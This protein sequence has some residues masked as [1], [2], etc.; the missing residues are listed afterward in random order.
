MSLFD[1]AIASRLDE[2]L[3]GWLTTVRTDGR[4]QSSLVWFLR[5]GDDLLIYSRADAGKLANIAAHPSVAF[6]LNSDH[7][8]DAYVTMEA[9]A[10]IVDAPIPADKVPAYLAKYA[11]EIAHFGWT[12]R[13]FAQLYPVLIR[14]EV[15]RI[16]V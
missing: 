5:E 14:L 11:G 13:Q 12:P 2:D 3:V 10:A 15:S 8:G 6:N 9:N 1:T 16:R 4:P 7:R